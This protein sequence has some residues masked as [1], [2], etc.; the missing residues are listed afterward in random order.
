M[1]L[2]M[3]GIQELLDKANELLKHGSYRRPPSVFVAYDYLSNNKTPSNTMVHIYEQLP[4]FGEDSKMYG[5]TYIVHGHP[6]GKP[7]A[8]PNLCHE[9]GY[10]PDETNNPQFRRVFYAKWPQYGITVGTRRPSSN[11]DIKFKL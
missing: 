4:D 2:K 8:A 9:F 11:F 1:S 10:K 6:V 3:A 5:I 7:C